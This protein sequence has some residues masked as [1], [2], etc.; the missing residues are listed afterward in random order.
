MKKAKYWIQGVF[1]LLIGGIVLNHNLEA[2]GKS[3]E[4][5]PSISL[6]GLCPFGGVETLYS[7]VVYGIYTPK[8]HESALVIFTLI[9][10]S[11]ILFGPV[12]CSYICPLGSVQEWVGKLGRKLFKGYNHYIPKALD[13]KL[14]YLRYGVLIGVLYFTAKSLTLV[15]LSVDPF[16]A[17]FNFYSSEVAIGGLAVLAV[18]LVGALFVERPWCKYLCPY[19]ALLGLTNL[20]RVFKIKR[21]PATCIDCNACDDACPMNIEVSK[22]ETINNHQCISCHHCLSESSCP[23]PS[24]V[25]ITWK[26]VK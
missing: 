7:L 25:V 3:L 10:V 6:H 14:R 9:M 12:F 18:T 11:S 16:H 23:L 21:V 2:L 20:I 22:K 1:L 24:T 17:L 8:I 19:G 4:W 15:F 26:E 13:R 5:V